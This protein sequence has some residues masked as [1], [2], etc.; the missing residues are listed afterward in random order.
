MVSDWNNLGKKDSLA[1]NSLAACAQSCLAENDCKFASFR[2]NDNDKGEGYGHCTGF[3]SCTLAGGN[4][5]VFHVVE[6]N[7]RAVRRNVE[8]NPDEPQ[9]VQRSLELEF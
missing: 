7:S 6:M 9:D 5:N 4:P 8:M 3:T 2:L 1:M